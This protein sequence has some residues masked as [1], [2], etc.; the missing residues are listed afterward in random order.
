MTFKEDT[1]YF[2]ERNKAKVKCECGHSIAFTSKTDKVV[3]SW[4]KKYVFKDKKEQ[5]KHDLLKNLKRW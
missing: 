1:R 5:F 4:C 3:C 2:D